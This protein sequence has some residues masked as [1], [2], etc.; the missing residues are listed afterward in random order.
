MIS[1]SLII[2]SILDTVPRTLRHG[3]AGMGDTRT[4]EI[5]F[6]G[7]QPVMGCSPQDVSFMLHQAQTFGDD[8]RGVACLPH[9]VSGR[10]GRGGEE[11]ETVAHADRLS[12]LH[13]MPW[14]IRKSEDEAKK[15]PL[16]I[17]QLKESAENLAIGV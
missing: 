3:D 10:V 7:W 13:M 1:Q 15:M 17:A 4:D 11:L 14:R 9:V 16:I 5:V 12:Y 6:I 2:K 8:G